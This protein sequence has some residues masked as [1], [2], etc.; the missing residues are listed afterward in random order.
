MLPVFFLLFVAVPLL[1]IFVLIQVGQVIGGLNT[2]LLLIITAFIGAW[3]VRNQGFR[4]WQQAQG[5]MQQGEMPGQ[6]LAEGMLIM[7]AGL[8]FI[9][10]GL[11]TDVVAL[12]FLLPG[13]RQAIARALLSRLQVQM[14]QGSVHMYGF[15]QFG[16]RPGP[17]ANEPFRRPGEDQ[18]GQ[19]FEGDYERQDEPNGYLDDEHR[20]D[21]RR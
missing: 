14:S 8:M 3:L 19:T 16:S 15:R 4:A 18:H 17:G 5:R 13:S 6:Q 2:I 11:L 7:I 21:R 10:P 9:T 12:F 1:E 20:D